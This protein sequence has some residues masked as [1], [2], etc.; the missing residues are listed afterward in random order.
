[1]DVKII[2]I[3]GSPRHGNT[4][5]LVK[6][7]LAAAASV[8]GVETD[9]IALCDHEIRGGCTS[10][11]RCEA[12]KNTKADC[13][14]PDLRTDDVNEINHRLAAAD[15]WLVGVPVYFASIPAQFKALMDRSVPIELQ[16]MGFRNIVAGSITVAFQ[17]NGGQERTLSDLQ[18]YYMMHDMIPVGVGPVR[19]ENGIGCWWGV[20][21]QQG[22]PYH[23]DET[24]R[25]PAL[26][27][28]RQ[29]DIG[30]AQAVLLAKRV[31]EMA[32]VIKA[33]FSQVDTLW[34]HRGGGF[35]VG[36]E[37]VKVLDVPGVE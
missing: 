16:G 23:V 15:G 37:A 4:E 12:P 10:C 20:A 24:H 21:A 34:P 2:G 5:V 29:D 25:H 13:L 36:E 28:V 7:A 8:D 32:K 31:V 3:S 17:R 6:H 27:A 33:G 19:P 22:W 14:H 11:Y 18:A 30:M 1:M 35:V 26:D 9:Y